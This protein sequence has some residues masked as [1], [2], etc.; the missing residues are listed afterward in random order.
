M[1]VQDIID[2][3]WEKVLEDLV[4]IIAIWSGA[5]VDIPTGWHLCDG[6]EGTIDLRDQFV[7]GAGDTYN[8]DDTGGA[9]THFHSASI[10]AHVHSLDGGD[11]IAVG[12]GFSITTNAIPLTAQTDV[13]SNLPP[14]YSLAYIQKT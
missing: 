11:D 3:L 14:Y 5:V 7:V 9:L 2:A 8:P 13:K 4:G 6:D 12:A 1:S 10:P